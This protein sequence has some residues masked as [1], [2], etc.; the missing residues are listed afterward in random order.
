ML[1]CLIPYTCLLLL[2]GI[3]LCGSSMFLEEVKLLLLFAKCLVHCIVHFA[4]EVMSYRYGHDRTST[5]SWMQLHTLLGIQ[6]KDI[7]FHSYA[8]E[9]L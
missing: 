5:T 8:F 6:P 2:L 3:Y 4:L 7:A 9:V 1:R